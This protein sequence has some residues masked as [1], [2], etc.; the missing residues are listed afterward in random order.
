V[1]S[2]ATADQAAP[3]DR[4][5]SGRAEIGG[6]AVEGDQRFCGPAP[7]LEQPPGDERH[8]EGRAA[9]GPDAAVGSSTD[10]IG[11]GR[12]IVELGAAARLD[13]GA[14]SASA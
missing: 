9:Q 8:C 11:A 6:F 1:G 2:A 4:V 10:N 5:V 12:G 7:R 13:Q 3:E 14:A